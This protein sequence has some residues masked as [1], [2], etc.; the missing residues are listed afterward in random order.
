MTCVKHTRVCR[1]SVA[2]AGMKTML[3]REGGRS[4]VRHELEGARHGTLVRSCGGGAHASRKRSKLVVSERLDDAAAVVAG[5]R[6]ERLVDVLGR[7]GAQR[8]A[9]LQRTAS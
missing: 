3:S 4:C 2:E 6:D 1:L 8:E 7:Q 5:E 9:S